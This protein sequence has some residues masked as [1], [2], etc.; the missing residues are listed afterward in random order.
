MHTALEKIRPG[1]PSGFTIT[2][3][4]INPTGKFTA[5]T[6]VEPDHSVTCV[7]TDYIDFETDGELEFTLA[8]ETGHAVDKVCYGHDHSTEQEMCERRADDI[9]FGIL[10]KAGINPDVAVSLFKK[11][12]QPWRIKNFEK[13]EKSQHA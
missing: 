6:H 13:W 7:P 2:R 1:I 12:H 5:S 4:A 9:A 10:Q 11:K 3:I 8:H